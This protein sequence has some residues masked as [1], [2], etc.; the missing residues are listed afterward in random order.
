MSNKRVF[1]VLGLFDSAQL[2]MQAIPE[3]KAK[4]AARLEAY[5]PFPIHGI[6]KALGLRKSPIGGMV[7]IMGII[8]AIAGIGFRI[9]DQRRGLSADDGRETLFLMGSIYPDQVRSDGPVCLLHRRTGNAPA[10]E[11][12]PLF[13]P[14]DAAIEVDG[15]HH[16]GQVRPGRRVQRRRS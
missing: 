13:P 15:S 10:A 16:A 12:P 8:G 3:V 7:L 11:P 6:D 1:S 14:P 9:V 5:S 4:V 2:L